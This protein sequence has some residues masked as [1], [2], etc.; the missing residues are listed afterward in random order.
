MS[1]YGDIIYVGVIAY[2][3]KEGKTQPLYIV[4][5]DGNSG[6]PEKFKIDKIVDSAELIPGHFVWS[7]IVRNKAVN[8]HFV[9]GR[10]YTVKG[11][12]KMWT[13]GQ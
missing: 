7:V 8:L 11:V 1:K 9:E 10:W 6:K 13:P 5:D 4:W 12:S 3:N 2:I